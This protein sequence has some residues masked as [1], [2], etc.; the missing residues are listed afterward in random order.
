MTLQ[1]E[2]NGHGG[3]SDRM[4]KAVTAAL[5][6]RSHPT[7]EADRPKPDARGPKPKALRPRYDG[8]T[9]RSGVQTPAR[10]GVGGRL[11]AFV[12]ERFP[13]ALAPVREA[14]EA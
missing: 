7:R 1:G 4:T 9:M 8:A 10:A 13:F 3:E 5:A 6:G 11:A 14:L 12:L 2:A